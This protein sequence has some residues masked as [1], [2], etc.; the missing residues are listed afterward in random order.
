MH[1]IRPLEATD[2]Y[3]NRFPAIKDNK[4]KIYAAMV[5]AVDDGVGKSPQRVK[6]V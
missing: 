2:K 3:L 1:L 5:S 6:K 4:R